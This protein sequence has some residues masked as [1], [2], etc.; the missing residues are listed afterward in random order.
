MKRPPVITIQ[1]IHIQGPMKGDI[2]EYSRDMISI[3]RHPSCDLR[4][5]ADLTIVSRR[6]AQ[7]VR[8]GNEFRLIDQSANGTFVNGKRVKETLLKEGDV[9]EFAD[10]G[11][12]VSFLTQVREAPIEGEKTMPVPPEKSSPKM[13]EDDGA[14]AMPS[15]LNHID[16]P[17]Q[18]P[19][20]VL[21]EEPAAASIPTASVPVIIQYG[22]MIRSFKEL[23]V[24]IGSHPK[25]DFVIER[26]GILDWHAQVFYHQNTY[27]IKDLTGQSLVMVNQQQIPFQT[28]LMLNDTISLGPRGPVFRFIGEGRLAEIAESPAVQ[29]EP[30]AGDAD[31]PARGDD[32]GEPSPKGVFSKLKKLF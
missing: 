28:P 4:F 2:G 22:P 13:K 29:Q 26:P 24:T 5:P 3:G 8:E 16:L 1:L 7:I 11:P 15:H 18:P 14:R 17:S 6:H 20:P 21:R 12:K 31:T 30:E 27:W 23:P 19:P 25:C 9:L 10:G 32:K